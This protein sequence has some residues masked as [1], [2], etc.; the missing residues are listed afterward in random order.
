LLPV[1]IEHILSRQVFSFTS[2]DACE[3]AEDIDSDGLPDRLDE[4]SD[5]DGASDLEEGPI[6]A[7]RNSRMTTVPSAGPDSDDDSDGDGIPD[8]REGTGDEDFDGIPNFLDTDSDGDGIADSREG[9]G[10]EDG[11]GIPNYLDRDADGDGI[12]DAVECQCSDPVGPPQDA[13]GDG[14]PNYLDLDSDGDGIPDVEEGR[15]DEDGNGVPDYLQGPDVGR[16]TSP[17]SDGDG[18]PGILPC[19]AW[20]WVFLASSD[21]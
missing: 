1:G 9:T 7:R 5:G 2:T 12:S 19:H 18:I 15:I 8:A 14:I 11:D 21:A 4:D 6:L 16:K 20:L 3:F 10:D 17:D 13:D